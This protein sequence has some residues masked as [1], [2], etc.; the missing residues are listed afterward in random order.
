MP[1]SNSGAF[2]HLATPLYCPSKS[3][4]L[5]VTRS[6]PELSPYTGGVG[7]EPTTSDSLCHVYASCVV[8][9]KVV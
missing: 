7:F 9:D 8:T 2:G 3:T 6:T 4:K 1:E 5:L